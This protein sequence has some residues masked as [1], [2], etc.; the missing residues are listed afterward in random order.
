MR[1]AS[2]VY[3]GVLV[4]CAEPMLAQTSNCSNASWSLTEMLRIG[5]IDG[6]AALSHVNDLAI[7][8]DGRIY[9]AQP[10]VPEVWIFDAEGTFLRTLGRAGVGPGEFRLGLTAIGWSWDSLWVADVERI[11]FFD[12]DG[13]FVRSI[14]FRAIVSEEGSILVPGVPLASGSFLGT[15]LINNHP[16]YAAGNDRMS[17]WTASPSGEDIRAIGSQ[18][19]TDVYVGFDLGSGRTGHE[20]HPLSFRQLGSTASA[21]RAV[22]ADGSA[23]W[24]VEQPW[25][26]GAAE[27][28]FGLTKISAAGDTLLA[29]SI[30]YRARSLSS[31]DRA[32]LVTEFGAFIA[33]DYFA[34]A[35]PVPAGLRE[36]RRR[37]AVNALRLPQFYP[38][39]RDLVVGDD[40]RLWILRESR[41]ADVD[42]W[43]VYSESGSL[44]GSV[45][46]QDGRSGPYP[47]DPRVRLIRA[48]SEE[49]WGVTLDQFDVPVIH[50]FRID[51]CPS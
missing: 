22:T 18:N 17:V 19:W 8:P 47:W 42:R 50:R 43:E 15:R 37:N 21:R 34:D 48:T 44:E 16:Q 29:H 28:R 32:E 39:V 41:P 35:P 46:F 23:V 20:A 1:S 24:L 9:V 12:P 26:S 30:A 11:H 10:M 4:L 5:G 33:G 51:R 45:T 31:S 36:R 7:G 25:P 27:G 6:D 2:L 14:G 38:P 3:L 49:V 40:G 13:R